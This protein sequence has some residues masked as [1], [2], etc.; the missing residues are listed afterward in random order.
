M[1]LQEME[2]PSKEERK[3]RFRLIGV[4]AR[5][6][7]KAKLTYQYDDIIRVFQQKYRIDVSYA[8]VGI[9]FHGKLHTKPLEVIM[10]LI[11]ELDKRERF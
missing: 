3:H 8:M 10:S 9:A 5:K 7:D 2:P 11:S 6:W 4:L 1:R